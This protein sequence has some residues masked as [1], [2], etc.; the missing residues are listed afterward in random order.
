MVGGGIVYGGAGGVEETSLAGGCE[1][2]EWARQA[3][4]C[5]SFFSL[6]N[7]WKEEAVMSR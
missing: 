1:G 7:H 3:V 5:D 2:G 6:E 4:S